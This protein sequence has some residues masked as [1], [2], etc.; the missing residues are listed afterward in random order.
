MSLGDIV[1]SNVDS[2]NGI[3]HSNP[4]AGESV[5]IKDAFNSFGIY[6]NDYQISKLS[7][8]TIDKP[9]RLSSKIIQK[10]KEGYQLENIAKI[11]NIVLWKDKDNIPFREVLCKIYMNKVTL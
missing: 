2:I 5:Q 11:D 10:Q 4:I 8:A 9:E 1:L 7:A 3:K 6:K